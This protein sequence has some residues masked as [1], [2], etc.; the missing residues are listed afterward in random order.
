MIVNSL[1]TYYVGI[2]IFLLFFIECE[3]HIMAHEM[4]KPTRGSIL[5]KAFILES[6]AKT[7]ETKCN[8]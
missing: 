7:R 5:L 8:S 1:S 2:K 6:F 4:R 3:L